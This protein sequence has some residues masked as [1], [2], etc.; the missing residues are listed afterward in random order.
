MVPRLPACKRASVKV[1]YSLL[2][3]CLL[4]VLLWSCCLAA[5]VPGGA[6]DSHSYLLRE[7]DN[8]RLAG[9]LDVDD[10]PR[11]PQPPDAHL[12]IE[13]ALLAL[14]ASQSALV[15]SSAH[16]HLL[17]GLN[18]LRTYQAPG[19]SGVPAPYTGIKA[20]I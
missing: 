17:T 13:C 9:S 3:I 6:H 7:T 19:A 14:A 4:E 8:L 16:E 1:Y 11:L 10:G 20:Y 2:A 12:Y 5:S 15:T 18:T